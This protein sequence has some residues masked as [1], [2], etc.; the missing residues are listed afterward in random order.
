MGLE[1]RY[2]ETPRKSI[3][4]CSP[5]AD[6]LIDLKKIAHSFSYHLIFYYY[7]WKLINKLW[8]QEAHPYDC[9][10]VVAPYKYVKLCKR[11]QT[12]FSALNENIFFLNVEYK[13]EMKA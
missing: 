4:I 3:I 1:T 5:A 6:L 13:N 2:G 10:C 11:S 8:N 12:L 7:F 9:F